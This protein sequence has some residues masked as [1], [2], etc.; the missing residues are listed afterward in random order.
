GREARN[1]NGEPTPAGKGTGSNSLAEPPTIFDPQSSS[2]DWEQASNL[3]SE[4]L[5]ADP[6]HEAGLWCMAAIRCVRGQTDGL[7]AQAAARY[8]REEQTDPHDARFNFLAAVCHLAAGE[9]GRAME[10]ARKAA[11]K[12]ANLAMECA[13]LL[14]WAAW[15][16]GDLT[17]A[18]RAL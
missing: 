14:G 17:S 13:Y 6:E 5:K 7:A 12:D 16:R 2:A 3:L 11:E 1:G 15:L 9:H 10:S 18:G 8:R 4:C